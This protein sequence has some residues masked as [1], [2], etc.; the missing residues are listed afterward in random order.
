MSIE[1][2]VTDDGSDA[3]DRYEVSRGDEVTI[4]VTS[5]FA[6]EVHV[7]GYNL[8]VDLEPDVRGEITFVA[9][10]PGVFEVE[11]EAASLLLFELVVE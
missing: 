3:E 4:G 11:L 10:V 1:V 2:V 7:H 5:T 9:D 6:D 8:F